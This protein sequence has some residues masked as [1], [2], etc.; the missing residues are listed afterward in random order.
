[1]S[2]K[3]CKIIELPKIQDPRGN[4]TFVESDRHI[5]FKVRRVFYLY[6]VP[7]GS[8]RAGHSL[9]NCYQF[10]IA[11]SGSFDVIIDDGFTKERYHLNRSY[12]GLY[13]P[14]LTWR[15]IDNFSSG[16][17]CM[18]LASEHY[19]ESDY[20]RNYQDFL[21]FIMRENNESSIS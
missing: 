6:D 8:I 5:P 12:Y 9:K 14:P 19:D 18:A 21:A 20:Y 10:L 7:G 15:E 16:A 13:I 11:M 3:N 1:M 2:I 17:V 4:L